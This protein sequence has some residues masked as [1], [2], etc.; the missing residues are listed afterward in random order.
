MTNWNSVSTANQQI[1][2]LINIQV[3]NEQFVLLVLFANV[4]KLDM[5]AH[6]NIFFAHTG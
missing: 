1:N 3:H 5:I 6:H 4:E 2:N